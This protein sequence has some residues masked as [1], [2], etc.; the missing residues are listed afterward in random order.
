MPSLVSIARAIR[1][2][3]ALRHADWVWDA[4]RT[5]YSALLSSTDSAKLVVGGPA[6]YGGHAW[7]EMGCEAQELTL[8]EC[9]VPGPGALEPIALGDVATAVRA[10]R[11]AS[12]ES[13]RNRDWLANWLLPHLGLNDEWEHEYPEPLRRFCGRGVKSWQ[14]PHQ[15]AG[16]LTYLADKQIGTYLEIGARHGGTFLITCEY[17]R[18]FTELRRMVA[19]DPFLGKVLASYRDIEPQVEY[20]AALSGSPAGRAAI[21]GETWDHVLIDGDH[22]EAGCWA[23]FLLVRDHARRVAFHDIVS[24]TNPGVVAVWNQIRAVT[25]ARRVFAQTQQYAEIYRANGK[26]HMGLGVVK[27]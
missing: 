25:P 4:V 10:I 6:E 14:F 11:S 9:D 20:V 18:R 17:L 16:Y 5:P 2:H 3:P 13:L 21:G 19:V 23:D 12:L 26:P 22:A 8:V 7:N 1:R 24:S 15:F 27:L